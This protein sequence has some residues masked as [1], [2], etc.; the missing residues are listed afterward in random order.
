MELP[1]APRTGLSARQRSEIKAAI[2]ALA[3][4]K[5][6]IDQVLGRDCEVS[7]QE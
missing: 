5:C 1:L 6:D 2:A 4:L 3:R 7:S